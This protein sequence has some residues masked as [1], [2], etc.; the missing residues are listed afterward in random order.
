MAFDGIVTRA[1][2]QELSA[3]LTSGRIDKIYQPQRDELIFLIHNGK[4][5]RKLYAS[6]NNDHPGIFLTEDEF[7]N[8]AE[9]PTFCMLLRKHLQGSRILQISQRGAE[10]IIEL[11]AESRDEMGFLIEK[12]LIVEIMGRHSNIILVDSSSGKILDSIKRIS[13]DINRAR[14]IL[15]GRDYTYPPL[16]GKIPFDQVSQEDLSIESEDGPGELL[17][18]IQGISPVI[19][20]EIAGEETA[21]ERKE[22]LD[23]ILSALKESRLHPTVYLREDGTPADFHV[24]PIMQYRDGFRHLAFPSVSRTI[25]YYYTHRS[26]SNRVKQKSAELSKSVNS[27]LKKL[28]LKKQRLLEDILQAEQADK[29]RLYGELLT[30]NLHQV[31]RGATSAKVLNY[32]DG[33]EV[34]I[35][36]DDRLDPAKN[37]QRYYKKYAKAKRSIKEKNIQLKETDGDIIYLESVS[38]FIQN[39]SSTEEVDSLREELIETGFVRKKR[40]DDK[41]RRQKQ[42]ALQYATSDGFKV[43][44]GRNNKENDRLTFK[45]AGRNDIWFHTK[46]IPG[47]HVILFTGGGQVSDKALIEAASIAAYHSKARDSENVPVD[48]TAVRHVKKPN[49][50]KPGMVIFVHNKTLYVAPKLP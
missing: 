9:P 16:Q 44:V 43:L 7:Q 14:Q 5:R 2:A 45:M 8:P 23:Q 3:A 42:D 15:P 19:A 6:C 10:R 12:K 49:G 30:A 13:A 33:E 41:R 24:V 39:A 22:R 36:L 47:S 46:D 25:S 35:P 48:Y 32:Y 40:K 31:K 34:S 38:T 1:V 21:A 27:A 50:A 26:S 28:Y 37:A 11:T 20:R 17:S 29:Y 18:K 4:E